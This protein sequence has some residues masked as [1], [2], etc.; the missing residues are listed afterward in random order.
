MYEFCQRKRSLEMAGMKRAMEI[1]E[2][3]KTEKERLKEEARKER[4]RLK[5]QED[6]KR[7]RLEKEEEA[8]KKRNSWWK[9]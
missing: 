7:E 5:E 9:F 6:E 2:R 8:K 3:K 4:R 1:V